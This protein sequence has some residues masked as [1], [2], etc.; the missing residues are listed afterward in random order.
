MPRFRSAHT[1]SAALL[2]VVACGDDKERTPLPDWSAGYD[3]GGDFTGIKDVED[4]GTMMPDVDE[5]QIDTFSIR[6]PDNVT[7]PMRIRDRDAVER[8]R[9]IPCEIEPDDEADELRFEAGKKV[10]CLIDT[11]ELDLNAIGLQFDVV[12]PE[13]MCDFLL[14][15]P[16]TFENFASG[17]G[18]TEV[19]Y[20]VHED[21]TFSDEMNAMGGEPYCAYD[22]SF[23]G[24]GDPNCCT[25]TY[26]R[27]V[28][29]AMTGEAS[30]TEGRWGGEESLHDCYFQTCKLCG[31]E[32]DAQGRCGG[33]YTYL[34]NRQAHV[35]HE[36]C[37]SLSHKW[38]HSNLPLANY[39]DPDDHEDAAP[40]ASPTPWQF[41]C[42]DDA[43]EIIAYIEVSVREWNEEKEFDADDDPD[44]LGIEPNWNLPGIDEINDMLDW[45]DMEAAG[46]DYPMLAQP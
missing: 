44:T 18:P 33:E 40:V 35:R 24:S 41:Y 9:S 19:A 12:V 30:V 15:V 22:H 16:Y 45:K 17:V 2:L 14:S 46:I 31:Y 8:N 39:Y 36:V 38:P 42:L 28:T 43:R 1:L 37:E 32:V 26:T 29:S 11:D 20:T 3:R 27:T 25:G 10:R 5:P 13:G 21:G 7:W 34:P 4:G 6:V 23:W